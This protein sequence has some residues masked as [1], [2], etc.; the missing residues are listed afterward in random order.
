[1]YDVLKIKLLSQDDNMPTIATSGSAGYDMYSSKSTKIPLPSHKLLSTKDSME[2]LQNQ[3]DTHSGLALHDN[4]HVQAGIIDKDYH[5]IIN[6]VLLSNES[7]ESFTII[8]KGLQNS[9]LVIFKLP[10]YFGY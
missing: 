6:I 3:F 2:I 5:D 10:T 1:M 7:F 9:K 4:I 8:T